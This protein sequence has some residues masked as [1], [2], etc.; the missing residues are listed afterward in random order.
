MR[1]YGYAERH[2]AEIASRTFPM[3]SR[4]RSRTC[5]RYVAGGCTAVA[6]VVLADP[7]LRSLPDVEG[8]VC[9]GARR[10]ELVGDRTPAWIQGTAST[11][12]SYAMGDRIRRPEASLVD[13]LSL[14]L[15]AKRAYAEGGSDR[16]AQDSG[17]RAV[18]GVLQR[19]GDGLP[20]ARVL[21]AAG[22]A[23][24]RRG[25]GDRPVAAGVQPLRRS[26]GGQP[27]Q[28]HGHGP[29]RRVRPAGP[30]SWP[31]S[32]RSPASGARSRPGRAARRS[33]RPS[34]CSAQAGT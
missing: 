22:R 14:R 30:R 26:A 6:A 33:F 3:R 2:W 29:D 25:A 7:S 1:L 28:R 8:R 34:A 15:S 32:G 23:A 17:G 21:R 5:N 12:D 13:L 4:I 31:G 24:L 20:G 19:R 16:S 10:R 11:S 9:A 27:G 18:L